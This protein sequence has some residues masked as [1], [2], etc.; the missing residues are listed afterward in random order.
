MERILL[1]LEHRENQRLLAELLAGSCHVVESQAETALDRPFDLGVIDGPTL[2]RLWPD[3]CRLRQAAEPAFLP[4]LLVT[5]RQHVETLERNV[6][7][8]IDDVIVTPVGKAELRA[9]V[10][11]LLRTRRLSLD[12]RRRND[13]LQA[14]IEAMTHDLRAPI[15]ITSGLAEALQEDSDRLDD[16]SRHYLER[17]SHS[18]AEAQALIDALLRFGRLGREAVDIRE[19]STGSVVAACLRS[20]HDEI[21]ARDAEVVIESPLPSVLADATLLNVAI[22]N[23][24]ANALKFVAPAVR[25]RVGLSASCSGGFCRIHVRDNG[26][27]IAPADQARLFTPFYRL[28]GVEQ[29][30]GVGLGLSTVRKAAEI[31]GGRV[32][33]ESAPGVGSDFWIE[34]PSQPNQ[35]AGGPNDD[36]P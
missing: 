4:L 20:L 21:E 17:I 15:R 11:V 30:P 34:L 26:I 36:V 32:G 2:D 25:P 23:I 8:V 12:L 29:Y 6:W 14:F 7:Q 18:S 28:H 31:M 35:G 27:G 33:L 3:L 5:R 24:I 16:Q 13:D 1:L 19:V 10:Q 9:R 22:C